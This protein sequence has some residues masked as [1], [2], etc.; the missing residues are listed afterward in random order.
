MAKKKPEPP[1][2]G[3]ALRKGEV[4]QPPDAQTTPASRDPVKIWTGRLTRGTKDYDHWA[5]EYQVERGAKYYLGKQW[6]GLAVSDAEKKY[7]INLVFATIETQ[8]PTLMFSRPKV[9]VEPRPARAQEPGSDVSGRATLIESTLQTFVDDRDLHF[10][11][12]TTLALN[13]VYARF[14][15]V[16][17][18]Y[19][20]DWIDNPNADKPVLKENSTDEPLLDAEQK[21]VLQPKR[22]PKKESLF[23]KRIAPHTFRVGPGRNTL[24]SNDWCAYY[25]WHYVE[26]VKANPDYV[27]TAELKPTGTVT[28]EADAPTDDPDRQKH[29]GQVKLWKIWD[30]RK[31]VRHVLAEGHDRLL[32]EDKPFGYLPLAALKFYEISDSWYPLPPVYN[33]VSPQDEINETRESMKL[34]RR[35]FVRRYM[36]EPSV[37]QPEFDKLE[38]GEDGVCIE[39]PKVTPPP[40]VPIADA[41]LSPANTVQELA[42]SKDDFQQVAGVSG[43]ARGVP[44]ADTATQANIINVREQIRE[45]QARTLVAAWLGEIVRL[46]MLTIKEKMQLPFMVKM[47]TDPFAPRAAQPPA[48][49]GPSDL[50]GA[51]I[52]QGLDVPGGEPLDQPARTAAEWREIQTEDLGDLDMDVKIDLASLSPVAED[53]QRTQW[54]ITLQLL[55]NQQLAILLFMPN[56]LAP[57]EP[58]PMLRKTLWLN[59]V[60]N[61]SEV[62]EIW[63]IGQAV[64][65][66]AADAAAQKQAA[67][68]PPVRPTISYSIKGDLSNPV[69]LTEFVKATADQAVEAAFARMQAGGHAPVPPPDE[70]AGGGI[71]PLAK[72]APSPITG[73]PA[74]APSVG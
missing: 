20:A 69:T 16:E 72:A 24:L 19:T 45:A 29:D 64:L 32:Q 10:T 66:A 33:W 7:V 14:G 9:T 68:N 49:T 67:E 61:D 43:E 21:P 13:D 36:R 60:K 5:K 53:A 55:T 48:P 2:P 30:L 41:D 38:A 71:A 59:G 54:N 63:R 34:H 8:K 17:V 46:M 12:E 15:L 11:G 26:D 70:G 31:K 37:T 35:R 27:N 1:K 18:G 44:Q 47:N 51:R 23:L 22:I 57:N 28:T 50:V 73:T 62:R 74:A 58:S 4:P 65:K 6:H 39:V 3:R 25:E 42:A 40:I 52:R 56:P